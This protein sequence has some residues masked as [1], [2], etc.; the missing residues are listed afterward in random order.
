M[1]I[2]DWL[3]G[4]AAAPGWA[5]PVAEVVAKGTVLL[6]AVCLAAL[7]LR[8]ASAGLRHL[9]WSI[10]LAG[11][12]ALPLIAALPWRL[13][14]LPS[15]ASWRV[16]VDQR[17]GPREGGVASAAVEG[18]SSRA[19]AEAADAMAGV[20][21]SAASSAEGHLLAAEAAG[22]AVDR[23]SLAAEGTGVAAELGPARAA[24]AGDRPGRVAPAD[25]A[26][27]RRWSDR[28]R[29]TLFA[30]WAAGAA[31]FLLYILAG[32]VGVRRIAR[33]AT[34]LD[35]PTWTTPLYEAADRLDL[36]DVPRL[37]RSD[38][39]ALPFTYGLFR[40]TIVLP[41]SAEA[42]SDDRRRAV[43]FHE[44]GHVRRLD[45]LS[46]LV[47]RVACALY[48]FHPLVWLA[49]RR[50]RAECE[51]ACDDLVLTAGTRASAYADHL[52]Q[53]VSGAA[54]TSAPAVAIPMAQ[55]K[56][57]EGRMLAILEPGV[58][59]EAPSRFQATTVA[60]LLTALALSVAAAAP[61]RTEAASPEPA[62]AV[63][64]SRG[65][66]DPGD[67]AAAAAESTASPPVIA[68]D[69]DRVARADSTRA[70][71]DD[72]ARMARAGS[73]GAV[74]A[75]TDRVAGADTLRGVR[76][77]A[78]RA[79][80]AATDHVAPGHWSRAPEVRVGR[81]GWSV[82]TPTPTPTPMP[83]PAWAPFVVNEVELDHLSEEIS[84]RFWHGARRKAQPADSAT[85]AA[86]IAALRDSVASV[87]AAAVQALGE[88]ED[89]RAVPALG[90]VAR[91]DS[92]AEVR[93]SAIW[94]LGEIGDPA[95]VPALGAVAASGD[96]EVAGMA[97]WALGEIG[98]PA[99]VPALSAALRN[100]DPGVRRR[101]AWALGEVGEE[102][103][104]TPLAAALDDAVADVRRMAAWA[105]GEIAPDRAPAALTAALGD[106]NAEVRK[107]VAWALGEIADPAS[108]PALTEAVED[109]S[110]SVR[111]TA[112]WA[113]GEI[114]GEAARDALLRAIRSEDPDIRRMAA[115]ALA[116]TY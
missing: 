16:A 7:V 80:P 13:E 14:V 56:E 38:E 105:L 26:S 34:P 114:G 31:A 3:F 67:A 103:G 30:V 28:A 43:L 48:W 94:A 108:A 69:T 22:A 15:T 79:M 27:V 88:I 47:G 101:A 50:A 71:A 83:A 78:P 92:D 113:L 42:W 44:L 12:L 74:P 99:A 20:S 35:S 39:V 110:P 106:E 102:A 77:V 70:S 107:I 61:A 36:G 73:P 111:R 51:R 93:R 17:I 40:P 87:R 29:L 53:I 63:D 97:V 1:E 64:A 116:R 4:P 21:S 9:V 98:D 37:L 75:D 32:A 33:R 72:A 65:A 10:G 85:V 58:R 6:V 46:H 100:S 112:L 91:S 66:G 76:A 104:V 82:P 24:D 52:L 115:Q 19:A 18:V 11:V 84:E 68:P 81:G 96:A 8:R 95:A 5:P 60:T 45:L 59:R 41:G 25:D 54:R 2:Q 86:L 57:F 109:E 55:R 89:P 90:A 23:I 49:A 62:D